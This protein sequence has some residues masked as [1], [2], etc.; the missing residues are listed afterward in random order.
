M[1]KLT[2][3][4]GY[5]PTLEEVQV[6]KAR[7]YPLTRQYE[8]GAI[9]VLTVEPWEGA[10]GKGDGDPVFASYSVVAAADE[11]VRESIAANHARVR[12]LWGG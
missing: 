12:D 3:Y 7:G 4:T 9:G 8:G 6:I 2:K 1:D 5:L 11:S 10:D